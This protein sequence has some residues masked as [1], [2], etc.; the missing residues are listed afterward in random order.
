MDIE[1]AQKT[2]S[3]LVK[4]SLVEWQPA[5]RRYRLHDLARLFA[6]KHCTEA[7]RAAG[8]QHHAEHY[9]TVLRSADAL[10]LEGGDAIQRGLALFDLEWGNI[11]AGHSWAQANAEKNKA[12]A[13]LCNDYPNAG[14]YCLYLRQ[15][16]RERIHWLEAA[17]TAARSLKNHAGEGVHG[18]NLGLAYVDLGDPRRA[19]EFYEQALVI[20]R[21]IGDQRNEGAWL[22]NLGLAYA[23]LGEPRRAIELYEQH[24]IIT[25]ET[26][27]RRG[28]GINWGNLGNTFVVLGEPRRAIEFF[29]QALVIARE[30]GDCCGEGNSLYNM[31]LAL[32][33]LG[34]RKQAIA[35]ANAALKIFEQIKDPGAAK[36]HKQLAEWHEQK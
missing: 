8:Q 5:I 9:A 33:T 16:P 4:Y 32:D 29:D 13:Q 34:E 17:L 11:Q 3:M 19:I 14:A 12:A 35:N 1:P 25:R 18:G 6:A 7:E 15:H 24:L 31:S 28:E 26:G 2:L 22:G 23:A 20:A 36:V 10:Y 27:D 30:I 21:E